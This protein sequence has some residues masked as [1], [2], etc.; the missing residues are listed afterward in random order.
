M[1][2][3]FAAGAWAL[4]ALLL[5]ANIALR[6]GSLPAITRDHHEVI[7]SQPIPKQTLTTMPKSVAG[8]AV[9]IFSTQPTTQSGSTQPIAQSE[10]PTV[11]SES[12][13]PLAQSGSPQPAQS[14]S[15]RPSAQ[16]D[17]TQ[18]P[19]QSES[20]QSAAQPESVEQS[21]PEVLGSITPAP[22]AARVKAQPKKKRVTRKQPSINQGDFGSDKMPVKAY[23][24]EHP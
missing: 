7:E 23:A 24:R 21:E 1:L 8:L 15:T 13:Q 2:N 17:S 6:I 10:Q 22:R 14:E 20:A 16:P 19:V 11:Q 5:F 12:A 18:L 9:G 4:V 3:Y